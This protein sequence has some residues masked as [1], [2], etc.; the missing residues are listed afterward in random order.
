MNQIFT[1]NYSF[2][3]ILKEHNDFIEPTF[4][5]ECPPTPK[6]EY[7]IE[8]IFYH[9]QTFIVNDQYQQPI[10]TTNNNAILVVDNQLKNLQVIEIEKEKDKEKDKD[11]EEKKEKE[12]S[13]DGFDLFIRKSFE[14]YGNSKNTETMINSCRIFWN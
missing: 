6:L 9:Q 13:V 12:Q 7:D 3:K 2:D 10:T 11:K 4:I 14:Y 5:I 1:Y 8:D